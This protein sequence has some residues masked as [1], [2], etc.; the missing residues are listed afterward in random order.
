MTTQRRTLMEHYT[1]WSPAQVLAAA[2]D[3]FARRHSIYAA[4]VERESPAHLALRG[5]GGEEIIIGVVAEGDSTRVTGSSYLFDM[6][7]SRFFAM[8]PPLPQ[9]PS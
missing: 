4:F 2:R 9:E 1:T 5:Q 7:I 3:F 8:L 6:Q